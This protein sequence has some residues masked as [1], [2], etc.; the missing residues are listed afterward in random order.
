VSRPT[1]PGLKSAGNAHVFIGG[2]TRGHLGGSLFAERRGRALAPAFAPPPEWGE[3]GRHHLALA[4]GLVHDGIAR[5]CHD[6]GGGGVAQALCEMAFASGGELGFRVARPADADDAWWF[7][8]EP[9]FVVEVERADVVPGAYVLGIV[10]D[11][12]QLRFGEAALDRA[13]ARALWEGALAPAVTTRE[14]ALA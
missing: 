1:T 9:G 7:G 6:V 5:A 13:A 14:E 10:C 12:G 2:S 3:E 11:D 4:L 8:E